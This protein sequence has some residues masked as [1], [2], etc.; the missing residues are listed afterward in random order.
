MFDTTD[1]R[2]R[3]RI[4]VEADVALATLKRFLEGGERACRPSSVRRIR[5][6]LERIERASVAKRGR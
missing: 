4:A 2:H 3:Q 6:A 5:A 1:P